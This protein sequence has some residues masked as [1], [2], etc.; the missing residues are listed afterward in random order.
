MKSG[1][2]P[3]LPWSA[4]IRWKTMNN[5]IENLGRKWEYGRSIR[6]PEWKYFRV[7]MICNFRVVK[8]DE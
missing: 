5:I 1:A 4:T 3:K 8:D 7:S 6:R 2:R